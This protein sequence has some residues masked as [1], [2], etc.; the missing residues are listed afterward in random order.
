MAGSLMNVATVDKVSGRFPRHDWTRQ[1]I[2][3]LFALPFPELIFRAQT[4]HR[5]NFTP[6]EVQISTLL[7]IK[8]GGCP[9]DCG[10]CSQSAFHET[11]VKANRLMEVDAVVADA[12]RAKADGATRF[13]MGAAWRGPKDRDMEAVCAMVRGVRALGLETCMTLGMLTKVQAGRLKEAGLDYYNHN[14]DTSPEYYDSVVTTHSYQ[15]RLDTLAHVR[16]AG[17]QVCCGGIVG[18]G[19]SEEDRVGL[20]HALATLPEHPESVP[21]NL[22]VPTEGTKLGESAA[23]DPV[24]FVRT[25]AV[26]RIVMPKSM[27]RLSA[28]R[29]S[30]SDETQALCFIAGANSIFLGE[31]LLT[32]ANPE[33]ARDRNLFDRLGLSAMPL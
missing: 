23:P 30:M 2:R 24:T 22:L 29:K 20:L 5:A 8:T 3:A 18:M 17:L 21:I 12:R 4:A 15:D 14:L 19:E 33:T 13:C 11:G 27:V 31:K 6:G 28:G 25:I 32:A 16:E 9:E 7:S 1:E 10:Y 26:A